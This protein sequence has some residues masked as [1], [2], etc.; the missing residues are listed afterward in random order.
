MDYKL[1]SKGNFVIASILAIACCCLVLPLGLDVRL[2]LLYAINGVACC[3]AMFSFKE[4]SYTM[5]KVCHIFLLLFFVVAN[6][7]Q[8]YSGAIATSL[9]VTFSTQDYILFQCTVLGIIAITNIVYIASRKYLGQKWASTKPIANKHDLENGVRVKFPILL[10]LS[11]FALVATIAYYWDEPRLMFIRHIDGVGERLNNYTRPLHSIFSTMVRPLAFVAYLIAR[12]EG[13]SRPKRIV[14][15]AIMAITLFPIGIARHAVAIYWLPVIIVN[16]PQLRRPHWFVSGML[17]AL[18]VIFPLLDQFK[19]YKG[20]ININLST[21]YFSTLNYDASQIFMADL[22]MDIVTNGKQLVGVALFFVPRTIWPS[23]PVGSGTY[24]AK[25]QGVW[26]NI[27]MP[28]WGEGYINFGYCGVVIFAIL[29]A[30]IMAYM[31]NRYRHVQNREK[32]GLFTGNY[33]IVL[34]LTMFVLRG[35]LLSSWSKLVAIC[36]LFSITFIAVTYRKAHN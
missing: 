13:V 21:K 28:Y 8:Y 22:Q 14:L 12:L 31:D 36:L 4:E 5:H 2:A 27:A 10:A 1:V 15:L 32:H 26:D 24:L 9:K 19:H 29:L 34:A 3:W 30:I 16:M 7:I 20:E 17:V 23:K 6:A 35:D 33:L 11:L 25:P 18:L